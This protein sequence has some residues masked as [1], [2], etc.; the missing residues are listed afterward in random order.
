[1]HWISTGFLVMQIVGGPEIINIWYFSS[2]YAGTYVDTKDYICLYLS[3]TFYENQFP[4]KDWIKQWSKSKVRSQIVLSFR[5]LYTLLMSFLVAKWVFT[6]IPLQLDY[7]RYTNRLIPCREA[8][9]GGELV[10][11]FS[12]NFRLRRAIHQTHVCLPPTARVYPH[13][14][15]FTP[16][17]TSLLPLTLAYPHWHEFTP[18]GTSLPHWR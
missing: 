4:R 10:L 9:H 11:F 12:K 14:H 17:G 1:M 13:W 6:S 5:C 18:T 2:M 16:T 7:Q 3:F 8:K 15:E